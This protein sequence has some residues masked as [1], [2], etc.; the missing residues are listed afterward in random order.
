MLLRQSLLRCSIRPRAI[1]RT[2]FAAKFTTT[3]LVR[4]AQIDDSFDPTTAERTTDE[5]RPITQTI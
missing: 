4:L 2:L 5:V 3:R 1:N